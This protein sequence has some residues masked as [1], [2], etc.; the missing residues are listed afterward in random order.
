MGDNTGR[1]RT[2]G[3]VDDGEQVV[4]GR[5]NRQSNRRYDDNQHNASV[6][7]QGDYGDA[8]IWREIVGLGKDISAVNI[9]LDDLPDRVKV[10]EVRFMAA[11]VNTLSLTALYWITGVGLFLIIAMIATQVILQAVR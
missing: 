8:A 7:F 10:L 6:T 1:D 3:T 5:S 4:I 11:P 2:E 9:R